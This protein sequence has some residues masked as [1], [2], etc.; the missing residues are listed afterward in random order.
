MS[1][2]GQ[3]YAARLNVLHKHLRCADPAVLGPQDAVRRAD[4]GGLTSSEDVRV[5]H[6]RMHVLVA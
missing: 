4:D 6:G 2:W 5:Q 1:H 3:S